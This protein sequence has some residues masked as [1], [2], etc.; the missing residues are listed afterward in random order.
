MNGMP[1]YGTLRIFLDGMLGMMVLY[2]LLSFV[3]Q[4]K[5]IY[6]Q[7]ALYILCMV[8]TFRLD[9]SDYA[10]A[11][12]APGANYV[13]AL[14]ESVAF[15]LYI[16]FA[17]LLI[18]IPQK[19][20]FSYRLM[21]LMTALLVVGAVLDTG[22]WLADVSDALRSLLYTVNRFI[23]AAV[24]LVVVP[25]IVR[26]RQPV[27]SYFIVG[28]FFF[29]S[30]CVFALCI[31][32]IPALFTRQAGNPF[33]FPVTYIQ[34]GVV[35]EVLCFTLGLARLNN[36]NELEKQQIQAQLI[37]QLQEN[38]RKQQKLQ[39]IRDD[40]AR[41]LHDELGADLG[42][43]GML[44]MAATRQLRHESTG[45]IRSS[46]S[47]AEE[48]V[49]PETDTAVSDKL[50]L[51]SQAS[52]RVVV[53]MREIIWNL[54]SIHDTLQNLAFRL[55]E[56]ARNL[57]GGRAI[58]L[59]IQLP[60]PDTDLPLPAE[61]RRDLFLLFK[62]ALHNLIRHA[63]ATEVQIRLSL[64]RSLPGEPR[65]ELFIRDN[66]KGFLPQQL[67]RGG[68]GVRSMQQRAQSLSGT[69][70]IDSG[71]GRGTTLRFVGPLREK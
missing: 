32:F 33:T 26:L 21:R 25:R 5:A 69:L 20:P 6:W 40:I 56:T 19:D 11:D 7:Y 54:N 60:S 49:L 36:Q 58:T 57:L 46:R 3:Q 53:T 17:I 63:E 15:I 59:D 22:L 39:Q 27:I 34:I 44:A 50:T 23:L 10:S 61:Y 70:D 64:D 62:E 71:P 66:G 24:A 55:E 30:G 43:I 13:V 65:I 29:V 42:G 1:A 18:N 37:E 35:L 12:Y 28:S 52:R 47:T 2:A 67:G 48:A 68:N 51:I 41:D 16:R 14:L 8:I 45:E 31:N 4:R 9:D 38:E